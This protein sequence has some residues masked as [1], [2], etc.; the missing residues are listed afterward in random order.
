MLLPQAAAF[1]IKQLIMTNML[2]MTLTPCLSCFVPM[3]G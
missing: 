3:Y 1:A 2:T